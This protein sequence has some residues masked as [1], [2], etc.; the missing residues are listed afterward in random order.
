[1]MTIESPIFSQN[2]MI[3]TRYTCEGED[4]IP[5]L[6]IKD[7]PPNTKSL[8]LIVHDPDAPSGD[9]VH[10]VLWNIDPSTKEIKE[11]RVPLGAKEGLNDTGLSG[12]KGPCPPSGTHRYYFHFYALDIMLDLSNMTDKAGLRDAIKGHIIEESSLVGLYKRTKQG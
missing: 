1:M 9:F 6:W 2:G 8:V 11:K 5:P 4:I 12:Y 10:W 7:T 3:P